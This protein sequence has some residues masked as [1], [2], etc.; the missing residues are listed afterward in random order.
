VLLAL[1]VA[2]S[3][4]PSATVFAAP[5]DGETTSAE[6]ASSKDGVVGFP[7]RFGFF[8]GWHFTAGDFDVLGVRQPDLVPG[9]GPHAGLRV[10]WRVFRGFA[11]ELE[12][13][14]VM[15][16]V[17]RDDKTTWLLPVHLQVQWRPLES[18]SVVT[19]ILGLGAGLIAQLPGSAG[20][21]VDLLFTAMGGVELDLSSA[22]SLRLT[23][24]VHATD[25]VASALSFSPVVSLGLDIK[26]FID[27]SHKRDTPDD[28]EE[29]PLLPAR[30]TRPTGPTGSTGPTG[31]TRPEVRPPP[32]GCPPDVPESRCTDT[33]GDERIDA[34]DRCPLEAADT[35]DGCSDPDGDGVRGLDDACPKTKGSTAHYGCPAPR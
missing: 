14:V 28:P 7:F 3:A 19:P 33:D 32:P 13:G 2:A 9:V 25:G 35:P 5:A 18:R 4:W 17:E 29:S 34:F 22:L 26:A 21:D 23:G 16:P 27:R 31:P 1:C 15:T 8:G 11:L 30:P 20:S 12:A 24:G 10:G 6:A